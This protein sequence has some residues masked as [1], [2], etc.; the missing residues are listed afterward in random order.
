MP[1]Y[2]LPFIVT[3]IKTMLVFIT[4]GSNAHRSTFNVNKNVFYTYFLFLIG[5]ENII[6][7]NMGNE[8]LI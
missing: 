4:R 5:Y 3:H 8:Q 7:A 1:R 2:I 6:D